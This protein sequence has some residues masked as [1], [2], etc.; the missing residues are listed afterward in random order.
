MTMFKHPFSFEGRIRRLEYG[1]SFIIFQF[2]DLIVE[3]SL[4]LAFGFTN[5]GDVNI[6]RG[7][8]YVCLIP[9]L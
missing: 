5:N 8:V 1:L 7:L 4:G 2:Y 9:G 6:P 3:G